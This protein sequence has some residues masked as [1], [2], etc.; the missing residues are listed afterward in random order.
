MISEVERL[1]TGRGRNTWFISDPDGRYTGLLQ[2]VNVFAPGVRCSLG[3]F[4][5]AEVCSSK[6]IVL[7]KVDEWNVI[8]VG[9]SL[10]LYVHSFLSDGHM[11]NS[12]FKS[13]CRHLVDSPLC[14]VEEGAGAGHGFEKE[15]EDT[16]STFSP[17]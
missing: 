17:R 3:T 6:W 5:H 7:L 12:T 9:V 15:R 13:V 2:D 11:L 8:E 10:K 4:I 14:T 16:S 1:I